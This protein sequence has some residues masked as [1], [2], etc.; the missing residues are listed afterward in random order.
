MRDEVEKPGAY[1]AGTQLLHWLIVMLLVIQFAVA[2]S[3]PDVH[4]DTR[5]VGLIAWHL[6]I[7]TFILLVMLVRL[8]WRAVSYVPPPPLDLPPALRTLSRLT[9]FLLYG[10][11]I[12]LPLLG[13]INASAR[14]W[15]VRLFGFIPLPGLVPSGSPWGL[16]AGDIHMDLALVLLGVAGLHVLGALYHQFIL[17]DTTLLRILPGT[18]R[19]SGA[20]PDLAE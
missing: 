4:K 18:G 16:E 12:V 13:W 10:L 2:W 6:S 19:R 17:R 5:P 1:N 20:D 3:M 9:H 7:G 8:G 11:L 14:G 15:D